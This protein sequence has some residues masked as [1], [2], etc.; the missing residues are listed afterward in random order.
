M[1]NISHLRV[2]NSVFLSYSVIWGLC[3]LIKGVRILSGLN[4]KVLVTPERHRF[5][6]WG[7]RKPSLSREE[8][9]FSGCTQLLFRGEW[10]PAH[11]VL[12]ND[13]AC[14]Q[15]SARRTS[16]SHSFVRRGSMEAGER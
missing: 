2:R 15:R 9:P 10:M 11:Q 7:R 1:Y 16:L 14:P 12:A 8:I 4:A 13:A 5:P 3:F 6:S